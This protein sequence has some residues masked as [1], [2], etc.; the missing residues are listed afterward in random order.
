MP[1]PDPEL[2]VTAAAPAAVA[3]HD[4]LVIGAGLS[5][6]Y[7]LH[8]L[9]Q[10]GLSARVF[11]AGAHTQRSIKARH[12]EIFEACRETFGCFIHNAD[13]RNALDVSP[14]VREAFYEQRYGE[15]GFG[16][17]MGNFRDIL[18]NQDANDTISAFMRK[19]LRERVTVPGGGDVPRPLR[20]GGRRVDVSSGAALQ[21]RNHFVERA[22]A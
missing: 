7:P 19:K 4:V 1:S 20:A 10:L 13:P 3:R 6:M 8:L 16:I 17:W 12:P 11:E 18:I 14:E 21:P 2:R 5:G 22:T 15:P 9:R